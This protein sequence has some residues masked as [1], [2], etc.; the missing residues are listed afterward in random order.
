MKVRSRFV[1]SPRAVVAA[2]WAAAVVI[3]AGASLGQA[4][5]AESVRLHAGELGE[6]PSAPR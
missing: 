1:R 6:L 5:G 2:V 3:L 4:S